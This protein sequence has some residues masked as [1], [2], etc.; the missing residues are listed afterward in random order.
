MRSVDSQAIV[1]FADT[2]LSNW[3]RARPAHRE[4]AMRKAR[5]F[6]QGRTDRLV[7]HQVECILHQNMPRATTTR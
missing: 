6:G 2:L 3:I 5:E 1:P 4:L 7:P